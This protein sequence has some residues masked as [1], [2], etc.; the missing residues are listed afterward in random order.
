MLDPIVHFYCSQKTNPENNG[1]EVLPITIQREG[2]IKSTN[3]ILYFML[4][5]NGL[6]ISAFV[7]KCYFKSSMKRRAESF[8]DDFLECN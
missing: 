8:T 5:N 1:S 4:L 6:Y 7:L 2:N 3:N